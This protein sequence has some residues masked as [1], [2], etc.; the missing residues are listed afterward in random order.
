MKK[1]YYM[2]GENVKK[3]YSS[4]QINALDRITKFNLQTSPCK[5]DMK[6]KEIQKKIT[7]TC[8]YVVNKTNYYFSIKKPLCVENVSSITTVF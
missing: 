2:S 7:I 4:D 1:E 6:I 8:T 5:Y 3:E